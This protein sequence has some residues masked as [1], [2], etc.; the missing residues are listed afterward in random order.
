MASHRQGECP[1]R[2]EP[3]GIPDPITSPLP[4]PAADIL[5]DAIRRWKL[6]LLIF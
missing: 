4:R 1:E 2:S 3:K 5:A 6:A